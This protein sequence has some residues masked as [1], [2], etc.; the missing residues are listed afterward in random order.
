[1]YLLSLSQASVLVFHLCSY[2]GQQYDVDKVLS[3]L[4]LC[5]RHPLVANQGTAPPNHLSGK[6]EN[7]MQLDVFTRLP[8]QLGS[9]LFL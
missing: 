4:G 8:K 6:P 1:M 5:S 3:P 2:L 7:T 9:H